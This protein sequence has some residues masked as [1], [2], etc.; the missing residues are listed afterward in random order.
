MAMKMVWLWTSHDFNQNF[1]GKGNPRLP[2]E[3][4][5]H[6]TFATKPYFV[7]KLR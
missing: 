6:S 4:H 3:R 2:T 5:S 7:M 1:K